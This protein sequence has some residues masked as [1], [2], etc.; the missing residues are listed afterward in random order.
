MIPYGAD[1]VTQADPGLIKTFGLTAGSYALVIAR[2]D[3]DNSI[4]EIVS[5]FSARP[6]GV[7]LAVLGNY[8]PQTDGYHK[9]V[10]EAASGE[11]RFLGGIYDPS[12]VAALRFFAR[13]Y[14]H[15]HQVGGTNPS[16]VESLAA[17][18]PI[19]AHDNPFNR[20]VAGEGA[21]Y[22]SSRSDC[23]RILDELLGNPAVLPSMGKASQRRFHHQFRWETV[24]PAYEELLTQ[25]Q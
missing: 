17:S 2:P 11:V 25:W 12:K 23:E 14:I 22:F 10:M 13:L 9:K 5:A 1:P 7:A 18:N 8:S 3:I 20:W 6:R 24:L 21:R 15:G 19:L 16:L 4:L